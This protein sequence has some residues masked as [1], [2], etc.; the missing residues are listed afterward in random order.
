MSIPASKLQQLVTP[1]SPD[2]AK[3]ILEIA[4]LAVAS[5]GT[6]A[7]EERAVLHALSGTLHAYSPAELDALAGEAIAGRTR[8]DRL[9]RMRTLA[10]ELSTQAAQHCAYKISVL[11]AL[12]DLAAQDEEFE[13]DLDIQEALE[14]APETAVRLTS[15]VNELLAVGE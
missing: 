5:D 9:A 10:A 4:C 1:Q 12:A 7:P 14:L 13:F 3:R 6:L 8:E 15:E 2:D 11:T